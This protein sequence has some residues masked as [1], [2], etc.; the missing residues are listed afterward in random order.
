MTKR[1][2][3]LLVL[4]AIGHLWRVSRRLQ[5]P[6]LCFAPSNKWKAKDNKLPSVS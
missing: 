1:C 5:L 6:T 4:L 3:I 2:L